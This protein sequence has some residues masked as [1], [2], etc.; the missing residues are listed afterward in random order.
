MIPEWVSFRYEFRS[1]TKFAVHSHDFLISFAFI[2]SS[3][4]PSLSAILKTIRMRHSPQ[5]TRFAVFMSERSSFSI[6]MILDL[7]QVDL[8]FF[9][10]V[11]FHQ[12]DKFA[13]GI[14]LSSD[15]PRKNL[16][17]RKLVL[18]GTLRKGVF[19]WYQNDFHSG[20]SSFH[21]HIFLCI[22][23]HDT[24]TKFCSCTGHSLL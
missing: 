13:R 10:R 24:E 22:C 18:E 5:I 23:L 7:P 8:R 20:T 6:Y 12:F 17:Y 4:A 1:R 19:T 21:I 15:L 3:P 16:T 14:N 11:L 9:S 2:I